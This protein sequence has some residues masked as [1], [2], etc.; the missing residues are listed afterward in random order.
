[1]A[2]W[3]ENILHVDGEVSLVKAWQARHM[4]DGSL[5]LSICDPHSDLRC[6]TCDQSFVEEQVVVMSVDGP[7]S[8]TP[9][10]QLSVYMDTVYNPPHDWF[11][12]MVDEH[13]ELSFD[14]YYAEPGMCIFGDYEASEGVVTKEEHRDS[15][16][17][18]DND[19]MWL[20][21]PCCTACGEFYNDGEDACTHCGHVEEQEQ[22]PE[23]PS[24]WGVID[25]EV[26]DE[27]R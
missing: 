13:P 15:E 14:M 6:R 1:M 19:H 20:G 9:T 8:L 5:D 7:V 3:C 11:M 18:S 27:G 25:T 23:A 2:N 10:A 26:S 22:E 12:Q 17:M 4:K 16:D 24:G 21:N